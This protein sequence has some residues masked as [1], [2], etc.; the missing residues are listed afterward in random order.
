M[1]IYRWMKG[2]LNAPDKKRPRLA[3]RTEGKKL[4]GRH[5]EILA[6]MKRWRPSASQRLET[7]SGSFQADVF[8][9]DIGSIGLPFLHVLDPR[10]HGTG[11]PWTARFPPCSRPITFAAVRSAQMAQACHAIRD[12]N[13]A[14]PSLASRDRRMT[15]TNTERNDKQPEANK[16]RRNRDALLGPEAAQKEKAQGVGVNP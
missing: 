6:G 8:L 13:G 15:E 9:P 3:R 14:S 1:M 4:K 5:C 2:A 12:R 16:Q 7:G 10:A 11:I